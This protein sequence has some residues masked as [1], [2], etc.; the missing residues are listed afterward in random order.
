ML[1]KL[2]CLLGFHEWKKTSTSYI[3]KTVTGKCKH[4]GKEKTVYIGHIMR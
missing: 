2:L 4:C 1:H 3:M